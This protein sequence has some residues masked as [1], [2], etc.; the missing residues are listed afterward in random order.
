MDANSTYVT[1]VCPDCKNE[2]AKEI[3]WLHSHAHWT[4]ESC[5]RWLQFNLNKL[6][7]FVRHDAHK[8]GSKFRLIRYPED[9]L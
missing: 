5:G 2:T 8:F 1:T 4:C 3:A 9:S 7:E 6:D